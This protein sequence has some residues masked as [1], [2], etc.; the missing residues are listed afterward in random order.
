MSFS[1][2]TKAQLAL[3]VPQTECCK[4]ALLSGLL[5]YGKLCGRDKI[6]FITDI[7]ETADLLLS[8]M[9]ELFGVTG[10][11]YVSEKKTPP[12][13]AEDEPL[14]SY[15]S[16]KITVSDRREIAKMLS[17]FVKDGVS[18]YRIN[19]SLFKCEKCRTAFAKGMFLAAGTV[20][21]PELS[22]HLEISCPYKNLALE[23]EEFMCG[24]VDGAKTAQRKSGY[25]IYYKKAD[26]I[27]EILHR[28]GANKSAFEFIDAQIIKN[29]INNVNRA[30]NCDTANIARSVNAASEALDAIAYL[31]ATDKLDSLPHELKEAAYLRS[32]NPDMSLRQLTEL[33][34]VTISK[35]GLNH[36][37]Q[38]IIA[39]AN[40]EKG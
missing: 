11:L 36:R 14:S 23:T 8:L 3:Q 27:I 2:R 15:E 21:N 7:K 25:I 18:L 28:L 29:G 19:N 12:E 24:I 10:N 34:G 9:H 1:G 30:V 20:T 40:K 32:E 35:S 5:V 22:Y 6:K 38:K 4:R 37:L 39:I 33:P 17:L 13:G 16:Y 26:S 31:K